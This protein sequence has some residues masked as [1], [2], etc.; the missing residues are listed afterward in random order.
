MHGH[1]AGLIEIGEHSNVGAAS[2]P[3]TRHV[4]QS[5]SEARMIEQVRELADL[6]VRRVMLSASLSLLQ[7]TPHRPTAHPLPE[8]LAAH[9]RI[10]HTLLRQIGVNCVIDVGAHSG[11]YG[12]QLRRSGYRGEIVSF[13]PVAASYSSLQRRAAGDTHWST[14]RL[15]LGSAPR[16]ATMHVSR[17]SVFSS[18]MRVNEFSTKY[19]PDSATTGDEEV[20]VQRLDAVFDRLC[21]HIPNPRV[22][23][24][25]DTQGWDLEV[26]EGA[27][28]CLRHVVALQTELSV[29]P[30]YEGQV[31]WLDALATLEREGFKPVHLATVT[32]DPSSRVVEFDYLGIRD[33]GQ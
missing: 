5:T 28:G 27:R 18:F 25:T 2:A 12:H 31:G 8:E 11:E 20:D 21:G 9:K 13:E 14:H 15:A 10:Q 7:R 17:K 30:I 24:K 6:A 29:R 16:R 4:N 26:I 33:A 32:R 23:L 1:A 19:M 3:A 22:L